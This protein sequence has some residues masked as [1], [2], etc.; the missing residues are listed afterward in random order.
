MKLIM[1]IFSL[2]I[3]QQRISKHSESFLSTF[4]SKLTKVFQN[5]VFLESPL[6]ELNWE[7][8]RYLRFPLTADVN[9]D[10]GRWVGGGERAYQWI[11]PE[12]R[13][14]RQLGDGYS[15]QKEKG[16]NS[17]TECNFK[18]GLQLPYRVRSIVES[19]E[20]YRW[21]CSVEHSV[22]THTSQC[23][24]HTP[25]EKVRSPT[26]PDTAGTIMAIK[27]KLGS[28]IIVIHRG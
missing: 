14:S 28:L 4:K 22:H 24:Q 6:S 26:S 2:L 3:N 19:A 17:W 8:Q 27:L 25:K 7:C 20:L 18:S 5:M 12:S 23:A 13:L 21:Y 1:W 9:G 16:P 15:S 10:R 11:C